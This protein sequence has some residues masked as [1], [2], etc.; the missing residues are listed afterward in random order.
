MVLKVL[1]FYF[2]LIPTFSCW[3]RSY[4]L[5]PTALG[6][7]KDNMRKLLNRIRLLTIP[8]MEKK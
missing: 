7:G 8:T 5:K 3:R 4:F 1:A 2:S 6:V